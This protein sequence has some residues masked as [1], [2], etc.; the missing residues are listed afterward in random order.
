MT[1]NFA[2]NTDYCGTGNGACGMVGLCSKIVL[3]S[4]NSLRKALLMNI[5]GG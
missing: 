4:Q 2:I 1:F 5:L 3:S